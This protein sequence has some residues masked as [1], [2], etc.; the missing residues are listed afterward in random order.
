MA[1]AIKWG[2]AVGVS[3]GGRS[4]GRHRISAVGLGDG[5]WEAEFLG[6]SGD[7]D[8]RAACWGASEDRLGIGRGWVAGRERKKKNE[9]KQ[10]F[11]SALGKEIQFRSEPIGDAHVLFSVLWS[12]GQPR[13]RGDG[14][15]LGFAAGPHGRGLGPGGGTA[16]GQEQG[17][18]AGAGGDGE[19]KAPLPGF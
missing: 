18:T 10:T 14:R 7:G 17:Q 8:L 15:T 6:F 5:T 19:R 9:G 3:D 4:R 1:G 12:V 2:W 11:G 13:A 16:A